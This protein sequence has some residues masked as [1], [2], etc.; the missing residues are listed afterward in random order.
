MILEL[1]TLQMI[2][3]YGDDKPLSNKLYSGKKTFPNLFTIK[4]RTACTPNLT[5]YQNTTPFHN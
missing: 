4:K 5:P 2:E 1:P 3:A